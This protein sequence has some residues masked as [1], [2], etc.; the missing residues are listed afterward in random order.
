MHTNSEIDWSNI[1]ATWT[2][3]F[4][5]LDIDGIFERILANED[6]A[7]TDVTSA[8]NTHGRAH[9]HQ[10]LTKTKRPPEIKTAQA[11]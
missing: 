9:R 4:G 8:N 5:G 6:E 3:A 10:R 1:F 2:D 7:G 11:Q